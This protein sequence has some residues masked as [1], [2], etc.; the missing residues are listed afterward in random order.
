MRSATGPIQ[1][2]GRVSVAQRTPKSSRA[3]AIGVF[4]MFMVVWAGF[5]IALTGNHGFVD[6]AWQSLRD[7]PGPIQVAAWFA[8]LP[9]AVGMWAWESSWPILVGYLLVGGMVAWTVVAV[10]GLVR[11]FR[12]AR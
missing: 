11:A 4:A 2:G 12:T 3:F 9:I 1:G 8:V 10:A 6:S 7:L 5:A